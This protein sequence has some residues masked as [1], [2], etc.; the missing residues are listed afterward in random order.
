MAAFKNKGTGPAS[1]ATP[2]EARLAAEL[3]AQSL[4]K[5]VLV[6]GAEPAEKKQPN[7]PAGSY[8]AGIVRLTPGEI[9][10]ASG[11]RNSFSPLESG[12]LL[13]MFGV[14]FFMVFFAHPI[15]I[16]R[17]KTIS[18]V[19]LSMPGVTSEVRSQVG[20]QVMKV[21]IDA[22]QTE[23]VTHR[24]NTLVR[25]A[26]ARLGPGNT[27]S[28]LIL[29]SV[30][31]VLR[32]K[33]ELRFAE[34]LESQAYE[35]LQHA[36]LTGVSGNLTAA[37]WAVS[38]SLREY[39][40][41]GEAIVWGELA[42]RLYDHA[43]GGTASKSNMLSDVGEMALCAEDYQK[44]C[45]LFEQAYAM[46][47]ELYGGNTNFNAY[48]LWRIASCKLKLNRP[49]EAIEY[50][51]KAEQVAAAC[52]ASSYNAYIKHVMAKAQEMLEAQSKSEKGTEPVR[53]H[54]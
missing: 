38:E 6:V 48:R 37:V 4:S 11:A 9:Q 8:A 54:R 42:L 26:D 17:W 24:L 19:A 1:E 13:T 18:A 47:R 32:A 41:L 23:G 44:A 21:L 5:P 35:R 25:E 31:S 53:G 46:T 15:T 52:G 39:S 12:F 51:R 40:R 2:E 27:E 14:F 34:A 16:L 45:N 30:A 20:L 50:A 3:L 36:R 33:Y 29:L 22:G 49:A 7:V 28:P 43:P 10:R